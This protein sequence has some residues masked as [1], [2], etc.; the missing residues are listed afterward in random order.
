MIAGA[1][2]TVCTSTAV[3]S[4]ASSADRLPCVDVTACANRTAATTAAATG[5]RLM[6]VPL[7]GSMLRR[8]LPVRDDRED[9]RERRQ[10]AAHEEPAAGGVDVVGAR[11]KTERRILDGELEERVRDAQP[12]RRA[13]FEGHRH[14]AAIGPDEKQCL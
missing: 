6:C 7:W 12:R 5:I 2:S 3:M 1:F 10:G 11:R 8:R 13:A 9:L 4:V 14:Q